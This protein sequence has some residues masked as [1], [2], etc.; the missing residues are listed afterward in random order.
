MN[1]FW[2][3][4]KLWSLFFFKHKIWPKF[5]NHNYWTMINEK[6][7]ICKDNYKHI[8]YLIT[9]Y[10]KNYSKNVFMKELILDKKAHKIFKIK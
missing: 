2:Y 3:D 6:H 1:I 7:A 5:F 4:L 9:S 8:Y 10:P